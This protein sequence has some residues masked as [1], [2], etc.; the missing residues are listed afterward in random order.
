MPWNSNISPTMPK[1]RRV[2][3][4]NIAVDTFLEMLRGMDGERRIQCTGI[5]VDAKCV[6][7]TIDRL[8]NTVQ[9]VLESGEF[10]DVVE[11][12]TVPELK[13][14]FTLWAGDA[15]PLHPNGST[16]NIWQNA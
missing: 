1:S 2:M 13:P 5:P 8:W 6:G 14:A 7:I 12:Y 10:A 16:A 3:M 15:S 4:L 11:G 9:L